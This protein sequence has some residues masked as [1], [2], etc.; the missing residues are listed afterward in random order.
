MVE[1]EGGNSIPRGRI[2]SYLKACKMILKGCLYHIIRVQDLDSEISPNKSEPV[3][4]EFLEVFPN[5]LPGIPPRWKM[6]FGID[7]LLDTNPI[8]ISPYQ[9]ALAELKELKG[10]LKDLLDKGFIKHC[11]SPWG[12]LD[13]FVKD[14]DGS[15]R[16]C[17]EYR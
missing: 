6:D 9:M 17:I 3:V 13:L 5:E 16:M 10:Q 12:A 14:K 2:I 4:S 7:L 15:L 11:I 8:S 1:W